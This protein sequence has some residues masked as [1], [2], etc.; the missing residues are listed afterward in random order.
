VNRSSL[1]SLPTYQLGREHAEQNVSDFHR[2]KFKGAE[3]EAYI[4][5]RHE[6]A[7]EKMFPNLPVGSRT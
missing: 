7:V 3:R 5:G 6:Y 4:L 2:R 1:R